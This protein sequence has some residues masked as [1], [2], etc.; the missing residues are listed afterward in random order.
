LED[1]VVNC[2]KAHKIMHKKMIFSNK[3]KLK[4]T[5]VFMNERLSKKTSR[6]WDPPQNAERVTP[7]K[8]YSYHQY[9]E[10]EMYKDGAA[11][12]MFKVTSDNN[13]KETA[14]SSQQ[15]TTSHEMEHT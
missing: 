3:K 15:Y 11:F 10:Q 14:S 2:D 1:R 9:P 13:I 7:I 4:G 12:R 8:S 5:K 6:E